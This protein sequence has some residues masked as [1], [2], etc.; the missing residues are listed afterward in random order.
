MAKV[1]KKV[2]AVVIGF[3]WTGAIMSKELIEAG[4]SVV[5]LER[6]PAH[7]T[8]PLGSYPQS[9]D[10]LT[11]NTR[12]KIF[13]NLSKST[14]TQACQGSDSRAVPQTRG[15]F[16]RDRHRRRGAA[17]VGRPFSRRPHGIA[18]AQPL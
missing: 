9:I 3:G 7:D 15:I 5:A 17:L 14:V 18:H 16:A 8:Y 12:H 11:Y 4:L 13:Q 1:M 10:E 6:G 2:D